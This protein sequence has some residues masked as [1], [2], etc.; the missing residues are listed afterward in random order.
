[1]DDGYFPNE[2]HEFDLDD[3]DLDS[4]SSNS[5]SSFTSISSTDLNTSPSRHERN[6]NPDHIDTAGRM[7]SMTSSTSFYYPY[8]TLNMHPVERY[9]RLAVHL[10]IM[11]FVQGIFQGIGELVTRRMFRI[12]W[13]MSVKVAENV[14]VKPNPGWKRFFGVS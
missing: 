1:M 8:N 14:D 6:N 5:D 13:P 3:E 4:S 11:P 7:I 10:L 2:N 9:G 12:Y